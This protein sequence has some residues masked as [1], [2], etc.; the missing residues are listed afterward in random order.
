MKLKEVFEMLNGI[1]PHAFSNETLTSWI[2]EIEGIVHTDVMLLC[3]EDYKPYI[4]SNDEST[5]LLVKEPHS[6]IYYTY[7]SAMVDFANGEY[8]KYQNTMQLFNKFFGEYMRW[9]AVHIKPANKEAAFKGYYISAYSIAVNHGFEGTEE[10]WLK[11]L[12]GEKGDGWVVKGYFATLTELEEYVSE[13]SQGDTYAVGKDEPYTYYLYDSN[14]GWISQGSFS[15][16]LSESYARGGTGVREGEETDNAKYY[17][18]RAREEAICAEKS[19]NDAEEANDSAK[20]YAET[21]QDNAIYSRS[22]AIGGTG[23]REGE[24]TDNAKYYAQKAREEAICAEEA[25]C[26]AENYA[27][28]AQDAERA[29]S[30]LVLRGQV[31]DKSAIT[32][33]D[34]SSIEHDIKVQLTQ[35]NTSLI[36]MPSLDAEVDV[37]EDNTIKTINKEIF[38]ESS[39]VSEMFNQIY[40][41]STLTLC[42][43]TYT[44]SCDD[45]NLNTNGGP[46][47]YVQIAL[48]TNPGVSLN[49]WLAKCWANK[50]TATKSDTFTIYKATTVYFVIAGVFNYNIRYSLTVSNPTVSYE[51]SKLIVYSGANLLSEKNSDSTANCDWIDTNSIKCNVNNGTKCFV[52]SSEL[53]SLFEALNRQKITLSVDEVPSDAFLSVLFV[54]QDYTYTWYNGVS[55][56]NSLTF[57]SKPERLLSHI[58]VGLQFITTRTDTDTV[59]NNI[60][61]EVGEKS[62]YCPYELPKEYDIN[63]DVNIPS[64]Y[65]SMI[66][67]CEGTEMEVEYNR[68]INK[69]YANQQAE[70]DELKA[71][72]LELTI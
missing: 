7:L 49:K 25:N 70:I 60:Q 26:S 5:E 56:C 50:D 14:F 45:I 53:N 61:L 19:K 18:Q 36:Y 59:I 29:L 52:Q 46:Y 31:L 48:V 4:Y 67:L 58:Q 66:L 3:I 21:V 6:K 37:N 72:I 62:P 42:P 1:K 11:A 8:E 9:Y 16:A 22:Y 63:S 65:P 2:N 39:T 17:A 57:I 71:M 69:A 47:D 38:C 68:D 41:F 35:P 43:G 32:I 34:V 12:K 51:S 33:K 10:E 28:K 27:Q 15:P 30:S 44:L 23:I 24:E 13:P 40:T 20:R 54:Y 55:G 64:I